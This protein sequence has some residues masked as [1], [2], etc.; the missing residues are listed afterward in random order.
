MAHAGP[1]LLVAI[2]L[3]LPA[4]AFAQTTGIAGRVIDASGA[5]VPGVTW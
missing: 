3:I 5:V 4:G 1:V 2:L